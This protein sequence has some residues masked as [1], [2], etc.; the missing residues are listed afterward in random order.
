MNLYRR[1]DESVRALP[2]NSI[3]ITNRCAE[4]SVNCASSRGASDHRSV[5]LFFGSASGLIQ[6]LSEG[7][8]QLENGA[9]ADAL[10]AF[11]EHAGRLAPSPTQSTQGTPAR[12]RPFAGMAVVR[13]ERARKRSAN[14]R[15]ARTIGASRH[16]G[17]RV[18]LRAAPGKRRSI[19]RT[20]LKQ[21]VS[22][23]AR[24]LGI[25][26]GMGA[27]LLGSSCCCSNV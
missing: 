25:Q 19:L 14:H 2:P 18:Q 9:L 23:G 7:V 13:D 15:T 6:A 3:G 10:A 27:A 4:A 26:A 12:G 20:G 21:A 17:F 1:N 8:H 24:G 11:Y 22:S 5:A 16:I